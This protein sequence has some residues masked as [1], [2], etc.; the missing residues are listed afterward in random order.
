MLGAI[1]GDMVGSKYEFHPIKSKKFD[2]YDPEMRM[3]DDSYLT[4][5]VAKVLLKYYPHCCNP[6]KKKEIQEDLAREFVKTFI[7]NKTAGF[8]G[9]FYLWCKE[10]LETGKIPPAYNSFGNGSAMRISPV[11]WIAGNKDE[12]KYLSRLVSEITHNHPEGIKGAEAVAMAIHLARM[13]CTKE[14]I[15]KEMVKNYYPEI[16][17]FDFDELK[18]T[19][20]FSEICQKSVPQAIYCF[21][22]SDSL[23]DAIR[24]CVA[25]GGDCDTTGAMAGAIA[26]SYFNYDVV[27]E[28]EDKFLYLMIEKEHEELIQ[29][30]YKVVNSRKAFLLTGVEKLPPLSRPIEYYFDPLLYNPLVFILGEVL[31]VKTLGELIEKDEDIV[32]EALKNYDFEYDKLLLDDFIE[33][34]NELRTEYI[35]TVELRLPHR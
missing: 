3:T 23:E 35:N 34:L 2:I 10:S 14:E 24:N 15:K 17:N 22:I 31:K 9:M 26:E 1:I 19:Y 21:L 8:G 6:D 4:M 27:S 5:A 13:G 18:R 29:R 28:L 30:F 25:I 11:G 32:Y 12:V 20:E 16:A 33:K 7:E